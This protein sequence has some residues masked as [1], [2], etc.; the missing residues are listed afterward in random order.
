MRPNYQDYPPATLANMLEQSDTII[1]H[2]RRAMDDMEDD[3]ARA[4]K[5]N[6]DLRQEVAAWRGK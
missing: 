4:R 6:N 1:E 5:D 2:Q 3:L